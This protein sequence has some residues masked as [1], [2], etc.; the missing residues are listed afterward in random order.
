MIK[1]VWNPDLLFVV[2]IFDFALKSTKLSYHLSASYSWIV[3]KLIITQNNCKRKW[4]YWTSLNNWI[5]SAF[6]SCRSFFRSIRNTHFRG[7][8]NASELT[9]IFAK[10]KSPVPNTKKRHKG[11]GLLFQMSAWY[12]LICL[13]K[14]MAWKYFAVYYHMKI[15]YDNK[16][17]SCIMQSNTN[18]LLKTYAKNLRKNHISKFLLDFL[19]VFQS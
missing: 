8:C 11:S 6:I 5:T 12:Q 13:N 15:I 9:L 7:Y 3:K 17:K 10:Q 2:W 19:H 1:Q 16:M 18:L 4:A 14:I